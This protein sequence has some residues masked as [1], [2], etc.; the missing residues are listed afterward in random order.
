M[1]AA[2]KASPGPAQMAQVSPLHRKCE[3]CYTPRRKHCLEIVTESYNGIVKLQE[4]CLSKEVVVP[5]GNQRVTVFIPGQ[6]QHKYSEQRVTD[7]SEILCNTTWDTAV[8]EIRT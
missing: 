5:P 4:Q 8:L 1:A 3:F 7:S 6:D 2:L